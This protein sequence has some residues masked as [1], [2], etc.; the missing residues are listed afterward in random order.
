MLGL[1]EAMVGTVVLLLGLWVRAV[2]ASLGRNMQTNT[3][4]A[5]QQLFDSLRDTVTHMSVVKAN[6]FQGLPNMYLHM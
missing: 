5:L 6:G 3:T 4:K 2:L 1:L